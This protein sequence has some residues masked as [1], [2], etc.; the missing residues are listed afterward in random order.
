MNR[1]NA[2]GVNKYIFN[3][4]I[5]LAI[6]IMIF[7]YMNHFTAYKYGELTGQF[8]GYWVVLAGLSC[9]KYLNF[10]SKK[11]Y[12]LILFICLQVVMLSKYMTDKQ[13]IKQAA[14]SLINTMDSFNSVKKKNHNK[15]A[16]PMKQQTF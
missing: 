5:I 16:V 14:S 15:S 3:S 4:L 9:I 1:L 8:L 6:S 12:V 2:L 7:S 13:E 11:N 10:I